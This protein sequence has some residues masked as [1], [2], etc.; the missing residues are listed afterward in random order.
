MQ[1]VDPRNNPIRF[2]SGRHPHFLP[3]HMKDILLPALTVRADT[4]RKSR[5][6]DSSNM[7]Q[8]QFCCNHAV[9][10]QFAVQL[11]AEHEGAAHVHGFLWL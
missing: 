7:Q 5:G 11:L 9:C 10:C 4:G 2:M 3:L 8:S 6:A 1:T